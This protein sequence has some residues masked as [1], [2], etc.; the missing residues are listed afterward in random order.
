VLALVS[1]GR[2]R[3]PP[4]FAQDIDPTPRLDDPATIDV[5]ASRSVKLMPS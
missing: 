5:T 2:P 4:A 1:M 3:P